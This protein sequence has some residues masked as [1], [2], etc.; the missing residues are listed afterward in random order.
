MQ[1]ADGIY[2]GLR[3]P[4]AKLCECLLAG[5]NFIPVNLALAAVSAIY[6]PVEY[7]DGGSPD[8]AA[9]AV[10]FNVRDDRVIR[11]FQLPAAVLNR[12]TAGW[13]SHTVV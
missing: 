6:R 9:C 2:G 10:A 4:V 8:I 5:K 13:Q 3:Q 11:N 7:T 12:S 1:V